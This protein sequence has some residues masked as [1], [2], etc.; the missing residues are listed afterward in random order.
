MRFWARKESHFKCL[1]FVVIAESA[2]PLRPRILTKKLQDQHIFHV[3]FVVVNLLRFIQFVLLIYNYI[4]YFANKINHYDCDLKKKLFPI[5][6]LIV[7]FILSYTI[8]FIPLD[9]VGG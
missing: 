1:C 7:Y 6:N 5:Y 8:S 3:F 2:L 4:H 9:Y